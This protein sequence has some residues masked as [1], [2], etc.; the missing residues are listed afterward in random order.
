MTSP[1]I[2]TAPFALSPGLPAGLPRFVGVLGGGRMG[3]G[4]AHAFLI[5]GADVLVVERD[6]RS[7][8]AARERVESAAA[9]SIERG[10]THANLDEMAGRL[11]VGVDYDAFKDRQLV[12]EAVPEDWDLK[13]SSLRGIEERL[14]PG[15]F[16]ASNTSS[17]SV[18]GLARELRR[19]GNFLGLHYFNPVPAST[20]IEVVLGEQT[21]PELAA[22]AKR[23][24]EALGKTAVVVNDAPG[25]ASSRLGVAIALEAMRMVEEG[26]ASAGDIDNAMVL[27]YKH[28]TGP[29]RTTDIVGLDVRLGIAEYLQST[30]GDRFAPPQILRDKVARGE[31]GRKTGKGFFDWS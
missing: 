1:L 14:A 31:L 26:V 23:W 17:L 18:N 16:L 22:E 28:P 6:E 20:L 25:F 13:V 21:S 27:G 5:K 19:P 7:A 15:A 9:K 10:A 8:E 29:L 24:V 30:L 4:I 11:T 2:Q 3:A 12:V